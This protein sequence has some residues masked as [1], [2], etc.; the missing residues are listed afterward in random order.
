MTSLGADSASYNDEVGKHFTPE[1][2]LNSTVQS[3]NGQS[4]SDYSNR[5][6]S[7]GAMLPTMNGMSQDTSKGIDKL[8]L[9]G[10]RLAGIL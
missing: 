8:L 10:Q 3:G 2:V 1:S 5:I 4:A 9:D 6:L 7:N